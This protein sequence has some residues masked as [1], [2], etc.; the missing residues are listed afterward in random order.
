MREETNN[1]RIK[2]ENVCNSNSSLL[3]KKMGQRQEELAESEEK[4]STKEEKDYNSQSL[5]KS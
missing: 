2:A 1:G 4:Q 3:A 5:I